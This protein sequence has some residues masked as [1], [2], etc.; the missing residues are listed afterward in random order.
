MLRVDAQVSHSYQNSSH[1]AH[2]LLQVMLIKNLDESLVNGSIGRVVRF[3]D[4][5]LYGT[6][7]D[8]YGPS[9]D[10]KAAAA[11][12]EKEAKKPLGKTVGG[13]IEYPVIEFAT[14][15]G[16]RQHIIQPETFKVELPSGEVQASRTQV[17]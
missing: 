14:N 3:A 17:S 8:P 15:A 2:L 6:E 9:F 4:P 1:V 13:G 12:K 10:A 7:K 5:E 11:A 16:K